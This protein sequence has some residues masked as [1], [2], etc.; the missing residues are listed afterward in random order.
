LEKVAILVDGGFY[1]K[2]AREL[3]GK[4]TP[5]ERAQ[6]LHDYCVLHLWSHRGKGD[7]HGSY[8]DLY[9]I[10]YYDCYPSERKIYH[11]LLQSSIDL[12]KTEQYEWMTDFLKEICQKRRVAL[13]TGELLES[14]DGYR[15]KPVVLKKL[16]RG[17]LKL[18]DIT[19]RD[20]Y[21]DIE[22][23]GV[24]M[25]I[26]LDIASIAFKKQASK[27]VLISGDSDFVPAA[28]NARREGIDFVL[29]PMGK[30]IKES[31]SEH[32]DGLTTKVDVYKKKR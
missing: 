29:D 22:Q 17:V 14:S 26:G 27:I 19:E 7:K 15:L 10:F 6:E 12:R 16:F 23:K 20:F 4:K 3:F 9:R 8:D 32:I 25:K 5:A 21:L 18:D 1:Q 11:P 2:R 30:N 31:L 28:K 13:R 24:D